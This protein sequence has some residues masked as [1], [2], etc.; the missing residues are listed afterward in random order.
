M[1]LIRIVA[2]IA[3]VVGLFFAFIVPV[4]RM[5]FSDT[6]GRLVIRAMLWLG[7]YRVA[8][9]GDLLVEAVLLLSLLLAISAVW[10][11]NLFIN[12]CNRKHPNVK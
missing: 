8:E 12:R 1:K 6:G 11:A 5:V 2:N 7:I 4:G 3:G 10:L 9:P